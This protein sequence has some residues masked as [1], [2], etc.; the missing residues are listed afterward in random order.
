MGIPSIAITHKESDLEELEMI[1]NVGIGSPLGYYKNVTH[2]KI[3]KTVKL[4]M[5]NRH[6]WERTAE[7]AKRLYDGQGAVRIAD[8]LNSLS[9]H[10]RIN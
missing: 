9:P 8:M 6:L 1:K 10:S 4:Y 7:R 3:R 5:N 2:S